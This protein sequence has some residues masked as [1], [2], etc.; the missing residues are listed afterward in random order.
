M[1]DVIYFKPASSQPHHI[2]KAAEWLTSLGKFPDKTK[3]YNYLISIE[4]HDQK[5][6][7]HLMSEYQRVHSFKAG[8]L[9]YKD[10]SNAFRSATGRYGE[11][12][13]MYY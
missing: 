5:T 13:H 3:A 8:Y 12:P 11:A 2:M 6:F 1:T 10:D 7:K 4:D 9:V